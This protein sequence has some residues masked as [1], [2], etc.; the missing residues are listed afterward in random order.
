MLRLFELNV[1]SVKSVSDGHT[2]LDFIIGVKSSLN[3]WWTR[4]SDI[5]SFASSFHSTACW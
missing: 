2:F 1:K 3:Q 5:V 4:G